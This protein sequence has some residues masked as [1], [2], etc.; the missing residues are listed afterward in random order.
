MKRFFNI[1][2]LFALTQASPS[3]LLNEVSTDMSS[4]NIFKMFVTANPD[5]K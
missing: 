4:E 5:P 3:D 1:A 2:I